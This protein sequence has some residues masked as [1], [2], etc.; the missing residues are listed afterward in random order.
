[1]TDAV[2]NRVDGV[3]FFSPYTRF[4]FSPSADFR[5]DG[6][7]STISST[8]RPWVWMATVSPPIGLPDPGFTLTDVMPPASASSKPRSAGLIASS[9]RTPAVTGSVNS[10]VSLPAHASAGTV[11]SVPIAAIRPP[12]ISTVPSKESPTTGTT[13]APMMAIAADMVPTVPAGPD[14]HHRIA[15]TDENPLA[16]SSDPAVRERKR[17]APMGGVLLDMAI[18]LDGFVGRVD[19]T[20]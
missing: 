18:S 2:P 12:C 11:T 10:L 1:M 3:C 20:D 7:R 15:G 5:P 4:G 8:V 6:E 9:A 17:G 19:E 14:S 13:W 16:A